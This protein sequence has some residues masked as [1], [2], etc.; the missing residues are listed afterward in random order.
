MKEEP[1]PKRPAEVN[2][3]LFHLR[4]VDTVVLIKSRRPSAKSLKLKNSADILGFCARARARPAG[5]RS[6]RSAPS[7]TELFLKRG[8][9]RGNWAV[10]K[11]RQRKSHPVH[12][13]QPS[14][15]HTRHVGGVKPRT[16]TA[17]PLQTARKPEKHFWIPADKRRNHAGR[18]RLD[19][20][21]SYLRKVVP[22]G[23][24]GWGRGGRL[25]DQ[26]TAQETCW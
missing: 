25:R 4:F 2:Q 11:T 9:P 7:N 24:G 20:Q 16:L 22:D 3:G 13:L 8:S 14:G 1:K 23:D 19:G 10:R 17:K 21:I 5:L 18:S 12:P 26:S 15:S 6:S